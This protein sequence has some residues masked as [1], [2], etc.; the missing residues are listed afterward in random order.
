MVET[1]FKIF[2]KSIK[3]KGKLTEQQ[4]MNIEILRNGAILTYSVLWDNI[5]RNDWNDHKGYPVKKNYFD[6]G[7]LACTYPITEIMKLTGVGKRKIKK[8]IKLLLD[9]GWIK[10][11]RKV[12]NG[13]NVYMLGNH[14]GSDKEYREILFKDTILEL[15][16]SDDEKF[17]DWKAKMDPLLLADLNRG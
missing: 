2:S 8:H 14:K 15:A 7:V 3:T 1:F 12:I 17:V 9:A 11:N 5:I 13:Q 10:K 6:K 16:K 4:E